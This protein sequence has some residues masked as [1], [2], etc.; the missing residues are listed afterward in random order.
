VRGNRLHGLPVGWMGRVAREGDDTV[1]VGVGWDGPEE[2]RMVEE[3]G[4][5][6]GVAGVAGL[7]DAPNVGRGWAASL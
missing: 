3:D 7:P 2:V 5:A 1:S 6:V 4:H